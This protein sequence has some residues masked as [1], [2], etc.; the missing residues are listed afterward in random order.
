LLC[1]GA[2][3]KDIIKR[4]SWIPVVRTIA[5]PPSAPQASQAPARAAG[6]V[7]ILMGLLR[8]LSIWPEVG[9]IALSLELIRGHDAETGFE[10][11]AHCGGAAVGERKRRSLRP[12]ETLAE[13]TA[14]A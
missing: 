2:P 5:V 6:V 13:L 12:E 3:C 8:G 7:K 14:A 11:R 4:T 10:G 9:A 1:V